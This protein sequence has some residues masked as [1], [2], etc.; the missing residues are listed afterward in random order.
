MYDWRSDI[1][2]AAGALK[3]DDNAVVFPDDSYI[4]ELVQIAAEKIVE[5]NGTD[6]YTNPRG[7]VLEEA[8]EFW[9]GG[10]STL[11]AIPLDSRLM[12]LLIEWYGGFAELAASARSSF[13][14]DSHFYFVTGM[15]YDIMSADLLGGTADGQAARGFDAFVAE[16][17]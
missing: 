17:C 8:R 7:A 3:N 16:R 10:A 14:A 9:N 5:E 15:G 1:Y 4:E 2:A 11:W 6:C 13:T 12:E